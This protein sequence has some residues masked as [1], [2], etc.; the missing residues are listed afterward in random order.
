MQNDMEKRR[1]KMTQRKN[2]Y[3]RIEL[4]NSN[5]IFKNQDV[6]FYDGIL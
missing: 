2:F 4:I 5:L 1:V 6:E 3:S